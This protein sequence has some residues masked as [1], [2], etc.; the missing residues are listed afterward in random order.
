ML[1]LM[2]VSPPVASP[3]PAPCGSL[4]GPLSPT[5]LGPP[6]ARPPAPQQSLGLTPG[7]AL[8]VINLRPSSLVEV[9]LLVEN[10][11]ERLSEEQLGTLLALAAAA[12]AATSSEGGPVNKSSSGA[13]MGPPQA[14]AS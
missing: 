13:P 8:Q 12:A 1:H 10:C 6:P 9:H 7:E 3:P 2:H 14:A 4:A 11:E 5:N